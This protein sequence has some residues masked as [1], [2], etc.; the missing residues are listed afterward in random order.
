MKMGGNS[1]GLGL[2]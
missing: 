1:W 2:D